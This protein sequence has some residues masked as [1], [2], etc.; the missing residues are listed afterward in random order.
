MERRMRRARGRLRDDRAPVGSNT[1]RFRGVS[2]S[3]LM[4]AC[5]LPCRW[6]NAGWRRRPA[7]GRRDGLSTH[8]RQWYRASSFPC[9]CL[10]FG[11]LPRVSVQAKGKDEGDPT[12]DPSNGQRTPDPTLAADERAAT[13]SQRFLLAS[14]A[15]KVIRQADVLDLCLSFVFAVVRRLSTRFAATSLAARVPT[16]WL[17]KV[18]RKGWPKARF[19]RIFAGSL[20]DSRSS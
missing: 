7:G 11:A 3:H 9:L 14:S 19:T 5:D 12:L 8:R 10:S 18:G 4:S 1:A 6:R 2:A 17:S 13:L 16:R 15:Q 20:C